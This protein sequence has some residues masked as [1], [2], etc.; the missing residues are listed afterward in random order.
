VEEQQWRSLTA[1]EDHGLDSADLNASFDDRQSRQ[2]AFTRRLLVH[3][4]T[5]GVSLLST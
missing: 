1:F 2:H 4:L 5:A 3:C